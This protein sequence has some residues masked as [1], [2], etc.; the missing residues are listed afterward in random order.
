M[1]LV[2]ALP[3][4]EGFDAVWVVVERFSKITQCIPCHTTIEVVGLVLAM[5]PGNPPAVQFLAGGS[6]R[7]VSKPGETP[8]QQLLEGLLPGLRFHFYGSCNFPYN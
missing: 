6:V 8:E 5:G 2:A 3:E 1:D 4:C 7:L